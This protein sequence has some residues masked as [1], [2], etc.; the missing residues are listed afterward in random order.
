MMKQIELND[1][2]AD[3]LPGACEL[4]LLFVAFKKFKVSEG[5]NK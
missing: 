2:A 4:W 3:E 1:I 5:S